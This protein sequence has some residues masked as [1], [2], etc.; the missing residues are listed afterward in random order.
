MLGR[1]G[2][3]AQNAEALARIAENGWG[4]GEI[5]CINGRRGAGVVTLAG[6]NANA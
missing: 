5:Y 3:T 6:T 4:Q 2:V 1:L